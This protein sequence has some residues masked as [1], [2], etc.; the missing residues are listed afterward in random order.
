MAVERIS[1]RCTVKHSEVCKYLGCD[2]CESCILY[3][4][5][6]REYEKQRTNEIWEVTKGNLPENADMIHE[7]ETCLF[8]HERPGKGK[9]GYG[10]VD[11]AHPEPEAEQQGGLGISMRAPVGSILQLPIAMCPD[12]KK[13]HSW[14]ENIKYYS[15]I[16]G[17][18]V[19]LGALLLT[20]RTDFI[21]YAP[22][23]IPVFILLL[24]MGLAYIGGVL[25]A[26]YYMKK[27]KSEVYYRVFQIPEMKEF[28]E[29]GWF[30]LNA[31]AD[32]TRVYFFKKKPRKNF[33]FFSKEV[34]DTPDNI[35]KIE[36]SQ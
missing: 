17:F 34:F 21:R 7:S 35:E 32:K 30:E 1:K 26:H 27:T 19:G 25:Y 5:S 8:C 2:G 36:E 11:I 24:G 13:K 16:L 12:C 3:K 9:I 22:F 33:V 10:L 14:I 31:E 4:P 28:E 6:I 18:L 29:K 23:Y 20:Y 15:L